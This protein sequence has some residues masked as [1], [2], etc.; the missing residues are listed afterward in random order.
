MDAV[1]RVFTDGGPGGG[2]L[3]TRK[4]WKAYV[5]DKSSLP[6]GLDIVSP[7]LLPMVHAGRDETIA[8]INEHLDYMAKDYQMSSYQWREKGSMSAD[9]ALSL[10]K[11]RY[12]FIHHGPQSMRGRCDR[13]FETKSQYE[14][15][16]TI[17]AALRWNLDKGRYP[18]SLDE[19]V[20]N[21]YLKKLPMDQYSDKPLVYKKTDDSFMLYSLGKDFDDDGGIHNKYWGIADE[22]GDSVFWPIQ[23]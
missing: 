16:L 15:T 3:I 5:F 9:F 7:Y 17:L 2:H 8:K 4:F 13:E 22:S 6:F 1:Q 19:L 14:A 21:G 11:Y 18:D 12:F 20:S 23:K 10:G